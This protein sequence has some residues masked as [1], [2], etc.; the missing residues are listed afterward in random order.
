MLKLRDV[1]VIALLL[2]ASVLQELALPINFLLSTVKSEYRV[3][4]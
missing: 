1:L 3:H 4:L 2:L